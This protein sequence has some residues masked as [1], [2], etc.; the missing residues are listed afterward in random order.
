MIKQFIL[1]NV[2]R[3]GGSLEVG[4]HFL[5]PNYTTAKL[6][7]ETVESQTKLLFG[8]SFSKP[9]ISDSNG[10][11]FSINFHT[12]IMYDNTQT[13]RSFNITNVDSTY[14][15]LTG[16]NQYFIIPVDF[17]ALNRLRLIEI[18]SNY[19]ILLDIKDTRYT[20][21][22]LP[23]ELTIGDYVAVTSKLTLNAKYSGLSWI[24]TYKFGLTNSSSIDNIMT[25]VTL[26]VLA[27]T[28][29]TMLYNIKTEFV[30][31]ADVK[32]DTTYPAFNLVCGNTTPNV[33]KG[34]KLFVDYTL[35]TYK[36]SPAVTITTLASNDSLSVVVPTVANNTGRHITRNYIT[37]TSGSFIIMNSTAEFKTI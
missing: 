22:V 13:V 33:P 8:I 24:G 29:G 20:N 26:A 11:F 14:K 10:V 19:D 15:E 18:A 25:P 16:N 1:Q 27:G 12:H 34:L 4:I 35:N 7:N 37:D 17:I 30:K 32:K 28:V 31:T 2:V 3:G 5:G 9:L 21:I 6:S 36:Y 23:T